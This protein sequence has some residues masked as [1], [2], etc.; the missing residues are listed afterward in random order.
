M[1]NVYKAFHP[2]LRR[3]AAIKILHPDTLSD[4]KFI[5]RF[6]N[7]AQN[8]ALLKH[9]NIVQ[10]YDA[11]ISSQF[12][13]IIMEYI[14]GKTLRQYI[15]EYKRSQTRIP[16]AATLKIMYS[17]GLALAFAHQTSITHRDVKPGNVLL[18][19]TDRV[20]LTDFGLAQIKD[21]EKDSED[22]VS[23]TPAY[24]SPEQALGRVTGP[25]SD[26][27]SYGTI[28][29]EMVTGRLPYDSEDPVTMAI[30]HVTNDIP[31]PKEYYPEIPDEVAEIVVRATR[32]KMEDRYPNMNMLLQDLTK[33]RIKSATAKLPTASLKNLKDS[34]D[35][36]ASWA[37]PDHKL[38]GDESLVCLH[39]VDTGQV[40]DL[41]LNR[42]Y[43]IGRK[44]KSQ[45]ILPDIDLSPFN[46]YEWGIS[47][48][49]ASLSV[50]MNQV[51]VSDIG[52]ANGTWIAGERLPPDT[53]RKLKHGD[54]L[55]L[56]KLKVQVLIYMDSDS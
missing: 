12:P 13:Y 14:E 29:F 50:Q 15:Q 22:K 7:E 53:P 44:H 38:G 33:I 54:V 25:R 32:R 47:R 49:H 16:I 3:Y 5:T 2:D 41:E 11:S 55:H 30:S 6:Q 1:A 45:P 37:P 48:L 40:L 24:I 10:V 39:I 42:E 17:I 4:P 36:V 20:V 19:D 27:Y 23:G 56:G 34:S 52:S 43:L 9:P 26:Q 35:R 46:A 31:S 51:I 21:Q 28:F 8:M 18:E